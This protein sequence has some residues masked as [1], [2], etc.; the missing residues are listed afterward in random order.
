MEQSVMDFIYIH[1]YICIYIGVYIH[2]CIGVYIYMYICTHAYVC[3]YI[4]EK[5]REITKYYS[6][7]HKVT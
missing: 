3:L 7:H 4:I 6:C 1:V 2:L 5:V